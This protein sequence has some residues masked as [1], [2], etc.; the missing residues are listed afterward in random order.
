ME[1]QS[2][3]LENTISPDCP[4]CGSNLSYS[5]EH[6]KIYQVSTEGD[7]E[8]IQDSSMAQLLLEYLRAGAPVDDPVRDELTFS[9]PQIALARTKLG[10]NR[11]FGR[12]RHGLWLSYPPNLQF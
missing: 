1:Y 7:D 4:S 8:L 12:L 6:K 11:R 3:Y 9:R 2:S 10:I 5:A